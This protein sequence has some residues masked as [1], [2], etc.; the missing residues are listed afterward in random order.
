M[1]LFHWT[2]PNKPWLDLTL[3]ASDAFDK[4]SMFAHLQVGIDMKHFPDFQN[5]VDFTQCLVTEQSVFCLPASVRHFNWFS[6]CLISNE[7]LSNAKRKLCIRLLFCRLSGIRVS[8]L[9]SCCGD[10]A[11]GDDG[12]GVRSHQGVLHVPLSALQLRQQWPRPVMQRG[13]TTETTW[14]SQKKTK[15]FKLYSA[16]IESC[17][18]Q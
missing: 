10:G 17:R 9:L 16:V 3:I 15:S 1:A 12:G 5:D 18:S 7:G 6:V 8:K 2:R 14:T 11:R 4:V 13:W